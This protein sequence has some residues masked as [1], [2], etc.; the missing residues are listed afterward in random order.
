MGRA[1][2]IAAITGAFIG[3]PYRALGS[4]LIL[5]AL[6]LAIVILVAAKKKKKK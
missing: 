3:T 2:G 4:S 5:L 1:T 6:I